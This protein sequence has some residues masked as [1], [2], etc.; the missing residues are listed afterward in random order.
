[1]SIGGEGKNREPSD[2]ICQIQFSPDV[3]VISA[4]VEIR[5]KSLQKSILRLCRVIEQN[6]LSF[7]IRLPLPG[8]I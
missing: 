3:K 1:V 2:I 6:Y 5:L 8:F 7:S 4:K